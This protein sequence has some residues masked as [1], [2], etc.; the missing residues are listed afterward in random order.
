[1]ADALAPG[2]IPPAV[3]R[4]LEWLEEVSSTWQQ[5]IHDANSQFDD[6][7]R[8]EVVVT[9]EGPDHLAELA[10]QLR[11]RALSVQHCWARAAGRPF[12]PPTQQETVWTVT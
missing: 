5:D 4:A 11:S 6:L 8:A 2:D 1:M 3:D 12:M 7:V 9:L 10:G